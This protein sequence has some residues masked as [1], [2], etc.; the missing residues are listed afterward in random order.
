MVSDVQNCSNYPKRLENFSAT[1]NCV[2]K[3]KAQVGCSF[4]MN[5]VYFI[6]LIWIFTKNLQPFQNIS[7]IS[8][9]PAN[10]IWEM[11]EQNQQFLSC[12]M[13]VKALIY[14]HGEAH[15]HWE[16]RLMTVFSFNYKT[17]GVFN[18]HLNLTVSLLKNVGRRL[19]YWNFHFRMWS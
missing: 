14:Y 8:N 2:K 3:W 15:P 13:Q 11:P 16:K 6:L 10:V 18:T 4:Y 19:R 7:P 12:N 5:S 9:C 1:K 17:V